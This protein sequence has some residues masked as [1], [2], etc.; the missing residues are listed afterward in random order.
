[1]IPLLLIPCNLLDVYLSLSLS[2]LFSVSLTLRR[3]FKTFLEKK[4]MENLN[5]IIYEPILNA[6][7]FCLGMVL[8]NSL[9]Q[10]AV[11][12]IFFAVLK[13]LARAKRELS[14]EIMYVYMCEMTMLQGYAHCRFLSRNSWLGC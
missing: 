10:K 2:L 12:P 14:L 7:W 9:F 13:D 11:T 8:F 3:N 6:L 4:I 1:M 5:G